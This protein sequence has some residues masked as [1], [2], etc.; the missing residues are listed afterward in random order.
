MA[1]NSGLLEL[2]EIGPGYDRGHGRSAGEIGTFG[3]MQD[4]HAE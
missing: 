4:R 2:G 3:L 1:I